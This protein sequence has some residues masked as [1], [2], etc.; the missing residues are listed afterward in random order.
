MCICEIGVFGRGTMH[1]LGILFAAIGA[2][3]IVLWRL[4]TA[5]EATKGLAET[6]SDVRGLF[7]RRRWQKKLLTDP[8]DQV[9]DPRIAATAMM[10]A[11]AQND[12]A[13]TE[14][15]QSTI[16]SNLASH[17]EA[18]PSVS[19]EMLAHARWLVREPRD[20]DNTLRK[21]LGV[22][23]RRCSPSE[24]A[25]LFGMLESVAGANGA[26]G[27]SERLA[28]DRLKITSVKLTS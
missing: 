27:D 11:L 24:I 21:L 25:D 5:A 16:L 9:D 13:L 1:I 15:E 20:I 22:I 19:A 18:T 4:H 10:V 2:L 26:L 3:G 14:R 8:L 17:F 7:R 12:G 28:M 23:H 6:A